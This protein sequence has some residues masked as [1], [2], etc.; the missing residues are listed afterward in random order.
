MVCGSLPP[1]FCLLLCSGLQL[2]LAKDL[3]GGTPLFPDDPV[4]PPIPWVQHGN[5]FVQEYDI[6]LAL[7]NDCVP[8]EFKVVETKAGSGVTTGSLYIAKYDNRS[9]IAYSELIFICATVEYQGQKGNWVSSIY[10]DNEIAQ[11]AGIDVWGLPKQL[12]TFQWTE[13]PSSGIER[14]VVMDKKTPEMTVLD[15]SFHDRSATIPFMHQTVHTFS[16]VNQTTIL[17]SDT[18]QKYGVKPF[19]KKNNVYNESSESPLHKY[20]TES[21]ATV[22]VEMANGLFNMTAP[23]KLPSSA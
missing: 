20:M 15:G 18:V 2:T 1:V 22:A 12:A 14:V 19:M 10:V 4:S 11:K 13:N 7:A 23:R 9:S 8:A 3:V 16:L 17:L 21:K 6:P 5:A